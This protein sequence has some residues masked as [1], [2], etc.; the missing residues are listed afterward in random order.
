[1]R[2]AVLL[3]VSAGLALSACG[4]QK[5]AN[6]ESADSGATAETAA[7]NFDPCS[8]MTADE[9]AAI[10]TDAVKATRGDGADCK[11][12]SDPQDD[13]VTVTVYKTGGQH[14]M[15]IVHKTS[16]VLGGMGDAVA[17]KGGAGKDAQAMLQPDKAAPPKLGDEAVWGANTSLAVRK[18]DAFV[19]VQTPIMHD[20]AT[21]KGYPLVPTDEKR[22]IAVDVATKLLAKL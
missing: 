21:H 14:Q 20:P 11:Y 2:R 18:G 16:E 6:G 10:T 19:Q 5:A 13:G 1:M 8:L 22:K 3:C 17:D 4:G 9:M 12:V 15:D 7:A